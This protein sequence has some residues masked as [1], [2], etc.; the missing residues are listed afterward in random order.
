MCLIIAPGKDGTPALLPREVFDYTYQRNNDGF[1]AMWTEDGRV[2]HFKTLNMSKD[3]IYSTMEEYVE[4]YPDV[5]FHMRLKTHGKIIPGLSHPFR[6]LNKQRHGKDLFFMHNGILGS[7]GNNL[8]YGQSDTTVFKDKVL[9]PLLTRDPDALED[10]EVWEAINKLTSGSRLAFMDS[11]GKTY[12]SSESSWNNRYGLKLSNTYML[13]AEAYRGNVSST[14]NSS[15]NGTGTIGDKNAPVTVTSHFVYFRRISQG[16]VEYGAWCACPKEGYI[17]TDSGKLYKDN[18]V[19]KTIWHEVD[20]IPKTEEYKH[21]GLTIVSSSSP[22]NDVKTEN[23]TDYYDPMDD[24]L[25]WGDDEVAPDKI[26]V[27]HTGPAPVDQRLRYARIVHNTY[28]GMITSRPQMVADLVG[29]N[30]D[31]MSDFILEDPQNAH[32]IMA[33]LVEMVLEYNDALWAIDCN[34]EKILNADVIIGLGTTEA[35]QDAMKEITRLRR[36]KYE[37]EL[38]KIVPSDHKE[39]ECDCHQCTLELQE[40]V[41]VA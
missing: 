10:P 13:P 7:F 37:E 6:I 39:S 5:I 22:A 12:F 4:R 36:I 25:P 2:N 40:E 16:G 20:F 3:E 8:K 30:D 32:T 35:H 41:N 18:G 19:N 17:R 38:K 9:I 28:G 26:E 27:E 34:H 14:T 23:T 29:M 1:G 24:P 21:L 31:E 11:E 33:E 15:S